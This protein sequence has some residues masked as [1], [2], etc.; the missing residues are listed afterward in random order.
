MQRCYF[1][2]Q[3][4]G[5]IVTITLLWREMKSSMAQTWHTSNCRCTNEPVYPVRVSDNG[6]Y[7]VDRN[8]QPV[9]WLGTTQWTL[10]HRYTLEQAEVILERTREK[11]F[12]Y[13]QTMLA[14]VGDGTEPNIYGEK[15]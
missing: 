1:Y 2:Y 15:P 12:T 11:G 3:V 8:G 5:E 10:W 4:E 9:F 14:G 13:I 7:F 6:R